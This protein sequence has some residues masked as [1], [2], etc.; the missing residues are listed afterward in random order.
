M[1]HKRKISLSQYQEEGGS[2]LFIDSAIFHDFDTYVDSIRDWSKD[3]LENYHLPIIYGGKVEKIRI[4]PQRIIQDLEESDEAYEDYE[5]DEAAKDFIRAFA[6]EYNERYADE[7]VWKDEDLIIVLNEEEV[8]EIRT[9]I[10]K[11]LEEGG[12]L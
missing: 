11:A 2:F 10:F 5:V 8:T 6:K 1:K 12:Q 9:A 3:S 4:Y 7:S